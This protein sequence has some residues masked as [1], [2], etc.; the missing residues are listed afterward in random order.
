M[1]ILRQP[2]KKSL[3]YVGE[4]SLGER[5]E[6]SWAANHKYQHGDRCKKIGKNSLE[7]IF[8]AQIAY[9][10][11][12]KQA[13]AVRRGG[14][15]ERQRYNNNEAEDKRIY[16]QLDSGG[17][18][19]RYK[20]YHSGNSVHKGSYKE[21]EEYHRYE[22]YRYAAGNIEEELLNDNVEAVIA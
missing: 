21:E 8:D 12:Y 18:D 20:Q 11:G 14:E 13:E 19:Y 15:A 4:K 16:S 7:G 22:E 10:G 3:K 1:K 17:K 9:R 6:Q 5:E 2:P